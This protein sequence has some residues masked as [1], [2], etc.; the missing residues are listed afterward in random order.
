[1]CMSVQFRLNHNTSRECDLFSQATITSMYEP[2][3]M[4]TVIIA[5]GV[6]SAEAVASK[7]IKAGE[8]YFSQFIFRKCAK[9][10]Y[11][12]STYIPEL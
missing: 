8:Y 4:V 11:T 3:L 9:S 10:T 1:M 7:F 6:F 12:S 2:A 5:D